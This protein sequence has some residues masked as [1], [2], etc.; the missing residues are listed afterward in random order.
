MCYCELLLRKWTVVY[1]VY[2][3][4][5]VYGF[6]ILHPTCLCKGRNVSFPLWMQKEETH[7]FPWGVVFNLQQL[8]VYNQTTEA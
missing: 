2:V 4:K 8:P 3:V 1:S 5:N 6:A 7:H